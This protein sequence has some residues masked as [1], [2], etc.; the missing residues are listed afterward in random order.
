MTPIISSLTMGICFAPIIRTWPR[1]RLS[2]CRSLIRPKPSYAYS[3]WKLSGDGRLVGR[4]VSDKVIPDET[5]DSAS[6]QKLLEK[7]LQNPA[8]FEDEAQFTK[9][10]KPAI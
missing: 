10:K 8:L 5:K 1:P 6:V 3:A 4:G 7:N 9:D 2:A